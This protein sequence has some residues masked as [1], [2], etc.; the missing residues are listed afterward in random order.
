MIEVRGRDSKTGVTRVR[1]H[2]SM[3]GDS[4]RRFLAQDLSCVSIYSISESSGLTNS[5]GEGVIS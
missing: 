4:D 1:E 2:F 5:H 3:I